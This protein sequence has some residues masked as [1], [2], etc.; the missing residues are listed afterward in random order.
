[1]DCLKYLTL[2]NVRMFFLPFLIIN[3]TLKV[4]PSK[5]AW[6]TGDSLHS[7]LSSP[8]N[9]TFSVKYHIKNFPW[10]FF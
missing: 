1:M 10:K 2:G 9:L 8:L 7:A 5:I 3:K 4:L 6:V